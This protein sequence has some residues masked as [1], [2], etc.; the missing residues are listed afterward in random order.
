ML[1]LT[2]LVYYL[3]R[4]IKMN[5]FYFIITKKPKMPTFIYDMTV[6]YWFLV[7]EFIQAQEY[8]DNV[9]LLFNTK[10]NGII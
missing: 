6:D 10:T 5:Q 1:I 7:Y 4:Y 3:N 2:Q 8:V 9:Y